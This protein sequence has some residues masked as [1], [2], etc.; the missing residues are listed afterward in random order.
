MTEPCKTRHNVR[1]PR[2]NMR[3]QSFAL[4]DLDTEGHQP[5]LM[6]LSAWATVVNVFLDHVAKIG[7]LHDL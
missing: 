7:G 3:S 6:D 1:K 5:H 2:H 4:L